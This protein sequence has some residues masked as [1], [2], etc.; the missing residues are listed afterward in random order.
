ME[1]WKLHFAPHTSLSAVDNEGGL[2]YFYTSA[3]DNFIR[4]VIINDQGK[5]DYSPNLATPTPR[6]AIAA[7]SVKKGKVMLFYQALED[8]IT[9]KVL[10]FG[11][12]LSHS[13]GVWD[14][15]ASRALAADAAVELR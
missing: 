5:M 15:S 6:S 2:Q 8:R 1:D 7:V 13:N 3:K 12:L 9:E 11:V 14:G 10:L 4:R